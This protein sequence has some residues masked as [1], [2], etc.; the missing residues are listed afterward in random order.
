M[1]DELYLE[2]NRR[3]QVVLLVLLIVGGLSIALIEPLFA[4]LTPGKS[5]TLEESEGGGRSLMLVS[6]GTFFVFVI[7]SVLWA[8]YFA[9]LG[10]RALKSGS[11]P[12]PGT[13]VIA[14]TRVRTGRVALIS[15]WLS[16]SLGVLFSVSAALLGYFI[17]LF[18]S[19]L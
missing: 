3:A 10:Y 12:P 15:G 19:A 7:L 4:Y 18:A 16:I 17:W 2:P 14:R 8:A 9:R 13:M 6:M 1:T 5:A 11:F